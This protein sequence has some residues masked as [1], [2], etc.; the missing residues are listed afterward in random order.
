[1]QGLDLIGIQD[2]PYQRRYLDAFALISDLMAQT[3]R[4]RLFPMSRTS[5]CAHRRYRRSSAGRSTS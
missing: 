4:L 2:E 5:P 1:M 3:E